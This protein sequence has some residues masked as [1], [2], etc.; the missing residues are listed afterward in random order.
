MQARTCSYLLAAAMILP[1]AACGPGHKAETGTLVGAVAG[2][3]AG[4]AIGKGNGKIAGAMVGA[5]LGGVVGHSI[6]KSMD[7]ADRR[8]AMEAEFRALE[9]GQPGAPTRWRNPQTGHYGD[10]IVQ[11]P[12]VVDSRHCRDYT[13]TIYIDGRPETVRG[14]ACRNPDGTWSNLG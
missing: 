4:A 7:E 2:G 12:Y 14:R 9:Y 8:A 3:A 11:Q 10:V 1:L 5:F 6:G 13:H